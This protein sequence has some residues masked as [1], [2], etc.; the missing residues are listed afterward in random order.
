MPQDHDNIFTKAFHYSSAG[1]EHKYISS[2]SAEWNRVIENL[3]AEIKIGYYSVKTL[4]AYTNWAHKFRG[5]MRNKDPRELTSADVKEY[6]SVSSFVFIILI[7]M[8]AYLRCTT[9]RERRTELFL[10]F[11][12][13][14]F[15]LIN[16]HIIL[17]SSK[18]FCFI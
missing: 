7:S 3:T 1:V 14:I 11:Q 16:M 2:I 10:K 4:K 12:A 8:Q 15:K 9:A 5:F 6:L 13:F 18:S 17:F